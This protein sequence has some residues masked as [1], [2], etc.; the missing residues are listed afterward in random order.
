MRVQKHIK[1]T[2]D[3][4]RNWTDWVIERGKGGRRERKEQNRKKLKR[5]KKKERT[6]RKCNW[7]KC[8]VST[9]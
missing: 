7:Y 4:E 1:R 9:S 6:N 8:R 2:T 5:K 3:E